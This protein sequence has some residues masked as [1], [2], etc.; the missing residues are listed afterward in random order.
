ML[1]ILYFMKKDASRRRYGESELY[2]YHKVSISWS[3]VRLSEMSI[4]ELN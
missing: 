1:I 3:D 4:Q 2:K